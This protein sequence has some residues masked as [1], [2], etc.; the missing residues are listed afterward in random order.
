MRNIFTDERLLMSKYLTLASE[1]NCSVA[2]AESGCS[3]FQ[4]GLYSR[5]SSERKANILHF[6]YS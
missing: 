3:V 1:N 5:D 2:A 4:E 6:W